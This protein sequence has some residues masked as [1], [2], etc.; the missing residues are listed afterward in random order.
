MLKALNTFDDVAEN[1]QINHFVVHN[2]YNA[3]CNMILTSQ[4]NKRQLR[5]HVPTP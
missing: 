2:I 1:A 3:S 4:Y 5:I